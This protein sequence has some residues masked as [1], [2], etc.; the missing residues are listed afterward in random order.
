MSEGFERFAQDARLQIDLD[1]SY[2]PYPKQHAFHASLKPFNFLGGAAGPGK[3]LAMM[4]E[5]M[6]SANEF[7]MDDGPQVHNLMLRRTQPKVRNTLITRFR[8][9][10][11][12]ELYRDFNETT[13]R[14][15][16]KNG[17]TTQ[18]GSMQYEH[19]AYDWQGQWF[20][21]SFDE[22][23]EFTFGQWS[24]ISAWNRCP[25]SQWTRKDGAGNPIGIGSGW[26]KKLFVDGKPPDEMDD[27]QRKSYKS[28]DYAYFPCTYLDNPIY[29]NDPQFLLNLNA[30][31]EAIRNALMYGTWDVAGGYFMGA[32]DAAE[33]VYDA[34]EHPIQPWHRRWMSCDWGFEHWAAA[35][36]HF[37]DDA[38]IIRTYKELMVKRQDPETLAESIAKASYD[39][40]DA[41]MP[42]FSG[43]ALSHDAFASKN[44]ATMGQNANP[45]AERMSGVLRDY[46]LP[47]P[48]P[49]TR[50]KVG[51]EQLMYQELAKRVRVGTSDAG[52]PINVAGWQIEQ[53]CTKLIDTI[54]IAV[55]DE[56][57]IE[58]IA[59]FLGDDPLQGAGY[60]L[61][62]I[63]GGPADKPLNV[64]RAE[65]LARV[66]TPQEKHM[67][68]LAFTKQT[69]SERR[70][71][72]WKRS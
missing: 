61:Y 24:A 69:E 16:W 41:K 60:G 18:F 11:P 5:D 17:A 45:V 67:A 6:I 72:K 71:P 15:L 33:N 49:S 7:N 58:K 56:K 59:L 34:A 35:Y 66:D 21:I 38:G 25:V 31:P 55:R 20:H 3:T 44:T 8:E 19:S 32:W 4:V 9:K 68:D 39:E 65:A 47:A 28:S 13:L 42:K 46:G 2:I 12:K 43:F 22:L 64:R 1:E 54:P 36:W 40:G 30:Y 53:G 27:A 62:M 29:A 70:K 48:S 10:I 26:V 37:M 63:V 52:Q 14:V 23:C 51:R 50:D 57:F